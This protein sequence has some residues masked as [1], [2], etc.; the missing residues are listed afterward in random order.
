[1]GILDLEHLTG[2]WQYCW[3]LLWILF[4]LGCVLWEDMSSVGFQTDFQIYSYRKIIDLDVKY[5][6]LLIVWKISY[7]VDIWCW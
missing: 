1:M 7:V 4:C 5:I 3:T 2:T 6:L